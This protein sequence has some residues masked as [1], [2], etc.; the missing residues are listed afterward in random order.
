MNHKNLNPGTVYVYTVLGLY[1]LLIASSVAQSIQR[2]I[3]L[4][5]VGRTAK[6]MER[7]VDQA[8]ML[9]DEAFEREFIKLMENFNKK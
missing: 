4:Q 5:R 9:Q 2:N 7:I 8:E 3:V 1:G 6:R